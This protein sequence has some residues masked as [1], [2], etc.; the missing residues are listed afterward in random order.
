MK[1][2][3]IEITL[4]LI[5]NLCFINPVF[6]DEFNFNVTEL[7]FYEGGNIIKGINGGTVTTKNG[8]VV[9]TADNFKYDKLTT[10]LEA[11]GNVVLNDKKKDTIIKSNKT[12]Y[13]KNKDEIYTE[14]ETKAFIKNKYEVD[15]TDLFFY[16]NKGILLSMEVT[17]INDTELNNLYKLNEFEYSLNQEILKGKTIEVTTNNLKP[18]SDKYFFDSG[19][20]D[21][22][23]NKFLAKDVNITLHKSLFDEDENDPRINSITAYGD[24]TNTYFNKAIFTSCKK[25]DKCPPWKMRSEKVHHDKIKKQITYKDAWL[26]IYDYPV[27]YFPKFFHP[28]PSVKRQSGF[29]RPVL[30]NS[31]TLGNSIYTPYFYVISDDKDMTIK[32]RF[33]HDNSRNNTF[34]LQSEY[35]QKTEKS[36][37][38]ADFSITKGHDSDINDQNDTRTHFFTHSKINLDLDEFINSS[39][40]IDYQKVSNDNY[41]KLFDLESPL[42]LKNIGSLESSLVLDFEHDNYDFTTSFV[43][44]ETLNGYNSDRYQYVLPSY[45]FSKNFNFEDIEGSFNFNSYGNNTLSSTNITTSV[46]NNDLNYQSVNTFFDNGLKNNFEISLKNINALGKNSPIYKTSPQ[47][48]LIS[49][50]MFTT[51]LPLIKNTENVTNT[52]EPKLS[53]RFSPHDMKNNRNSNRRMD[54]NNIFNINRLGLGN[55]FEGG[56]SITLGLD[57]KKE[58]E[59]LKKEKNDPKNAIIEIENYLDFKLATVFRL[60]EEENIPTSSTLNKKNSNI[61]GEFNYKPTQNMSL[62]Y[63]FSLT[64][65]LNTFEYNSIGARLDFDSF[66]TE[67]DF[68][69]ER[70]VVGRQNVI[71]NSTGYNFNEENSLSF[72]TRKNRSINLTEYY[73]LLYQYKNDCLIAGVQFRKKYYQ[74]RDIKPLEE[75]FFSITIVPFTTFSPDRMILQ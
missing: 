40:V 33:Y 6:S 71:E 8:N 46:V 66:Y 68:L 31:E 3:F 10:L 54:V 59:I 2:R 67:F 24:E 63:D 50:Y 39:L 41:L 58:R 49:A 4:I 56:Q 60:N 18:E 16:R 25:T 7:Q 72:S 53:F 45:N 44:Y 32:P 52:L 70:G 47:S 36:Y 35:K 51:S 20:F 57:F 14:G 13:L 26:E 64:D 74:N 73:N 27:A 17:F 42:L 43:M 22:K 48:E 69:E 30:G 29:L 1:N 75:L 19:F 21:F 9:I 62:N 61:F 55:S 11:E 34:V 15:T 38:I 28:D 65:D 5:I 37:T 12:F 23:E